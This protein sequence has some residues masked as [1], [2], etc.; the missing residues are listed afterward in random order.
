MLSREVLTKL[1]H[2]RYP[3]L[4]KARVRLQNAALLLNVVAAAVL[5]FAIVMFAKW[6]DFDQA[7][8]IG[9][10]FLLGIGVLSATF[11][12]GV[13]V[14]LS[15][16]GDSARALADIAVNTDPTLSDVDTEEAAASSED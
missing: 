15:A 13:A 10:F 4:I 7:K 11:F 12:R 8:E 14:L 16:F 6:V 2:E 3:G 9:A 5:I 1:A